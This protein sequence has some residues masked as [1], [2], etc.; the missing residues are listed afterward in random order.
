MTHYYFSLLE[1]LRILAEAFMGEFFETIKEK[2]D[3]SQMA[4]VPACILKKL[5]EQCSIC[6]V[7]FDENECTECPCGGCDVPDE[8]CIVC[9]TIR[10]TPI[11]PDEILE[12]IPEQLDCDIQKV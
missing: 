5:F 1:V 7:A 3:F 12:N 10:N 9:Y 11:S 6:N 2:L 4:L 8:L